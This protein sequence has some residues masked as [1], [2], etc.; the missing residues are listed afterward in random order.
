MAHVS[1]AERRP[2]LIKAAIDLMAREGVAAGSTRAIAAELGVA[3]AT[4][5]Y[6]FG[7]KEDLYRAVIE[8]LTQELVERV[9]QAAPADAGF[10]ET[11]GVLAS[12]LWRTVRDQSKSYQLL[13]ELGLFAIRSP[14]LREALEAHNLGVVNVTSGL[15]AEAAERTGQQ[16]AQPAPMIARFF[17]AG[18]DGLTLQRLAHPDDEAEFLCLQALVSSTVALARGRVEMVAVPRDLATGS[19][20]SA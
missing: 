5:H 8:H 7:T 11:V 20:S 16:L 10:E 18:F 12:A 14:H 17:L 2:Q 6:T 15:V 3:Q 13:T 9:R 1:A 19:P 4:V